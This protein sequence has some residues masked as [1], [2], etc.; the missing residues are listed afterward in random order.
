MSSY[1]MLPEGSQVKCW[2]CE[3]E[4]KQVGDTVP[5]LGLANYTVLVREGGYVKVDNNVIAV[6]VEDGIR[7]SPEDFPTS[8]C[9]D[10]WGSLLVTA[11]DLKATGLIGEDYYYD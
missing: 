7:R 10:K 4:T 8:I 2:G 11:G 6:I 3:G 9:L 1:D 5:D